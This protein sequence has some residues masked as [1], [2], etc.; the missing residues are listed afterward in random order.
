MYRVIK[1]N[2]R[3]GRVQKRVFLL[4]VLLLGSERVHENK[5][6]DFHCAYIYVEIRDGD[7]VC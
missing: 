5:K 1:R 7:R 3:A 4:R 2:Y 6:C